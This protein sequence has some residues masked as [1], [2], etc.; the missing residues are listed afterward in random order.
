MTIR[1]SLTVALVAPLL[2]ASCSGRAKDQELQDLKNQVAE[3]QKNFADLNLRMNNVDSRIEI[4][5]QKST[6]IDTRVKA[7]DAQRSS[8][9]EI[10]RVTPPAETA[11][12]PAPS[13]VE[14]ATPPRFTNENLEKMDPI[15]LYNDTFLKLQKGKLEQAEKGF[16][17]FV[18]LYPTHENADNAYYWIGEILYSRRSY[19][20]AL[21]T[22][23]SLIERY[24]KGNKVPDAL[25]KVGYCYLQLGEIEKARENFQKVI[26]D[27]PFSFA[28]S[29][30][31]RKL[32]EIQ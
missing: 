23:N 30:A 27:H 32:E 1:A 16:K 19:P 10:T 4:V 20:S 24:P 25:V 17:D 12:K 11:P 5:N 13:T 28:A 14:G 3:L 18:Q 2:L 8:P 9:V 22:F 31:Q 26:D 7:L 15:S 29:Q 6:D 21:E